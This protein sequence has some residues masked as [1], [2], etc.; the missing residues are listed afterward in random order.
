MFAE[1][2]ALRDSPKGARKKRKKVAKKKD[3]KI[4]EFNSFDILFSFLRRLFPLHCLRS[5][6][7]YSIFSLSV[8]S[9]IFTIYSCSSASISP[10]FLFGAN[11]LLTLIFIIHCLSFF[12]FSYLSFFLPSFHLILSCLVLSSSLPSPSVSLSPI[13]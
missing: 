9:L 1:R 12:L 4:Q 8:L 5:Q 3:F 6:L 13:L 11:H 10:H 2:D 7:Y